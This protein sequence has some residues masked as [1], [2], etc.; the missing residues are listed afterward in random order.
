MHVDSRAGASSSSED[1]TRP[2][3]P[4]P[5]LAAQFAPPAVRS[6]IVPRTALLRRLLADRQA[7]VVAVV[8]PPG[9][10]KTTLLAQWAARDRRPFAWLSLDARCNDPVVLVASLAV[11]LSQGVPVPPAV[12]DHLVAAHRP[13][14]EAVVAELAAAVARARR[15][16]VLVLDD[17]HLLTD[18]EGLDALRTLLHHLPVDCGFAVAGRREPPLGLPRLRGEGRV[19]DI[20]AAELRLDA[21]GARDL[22]AAAGVELPS[23]RVVDLVAATEG[24]PIGLYFAALAH[25]G[26]AGPP[27]PVEGFSGEDRLLADYL[28]TEVL[29]HLPAHRRRFLT[30]TSVL[31]ELSGPLCDA[32]LE[33]SGSAADLEEIEASNLLLV[34]LDRQRHWYRFHRLFQGLLRHE[35]EREEPEAVRPLAG[36]ASRWCETHDLFDSAVRYAQVAGDVGRVNEILRRGTMRQFAA[37]RAA[38]LQEWFGWLAEQGGVDGGVA[39]LGAWVSALSGRPAEADHWAA[40]ARAGDPTAEQPDGSP[41][42]AWVH[43]V[44]AVMAHSAP[45][46]RRDAEQ[47]LRLLSPASQWRGVAAAGLGIAQLLDGDPDRADRTLADAV[48]V[49]LHVGA[50]TASAVALAVRALIAM[51]RDA[52]P[53]AD[54]FLDEAAEVIANGHLQGYPT[55]GIDHAA[56]ACVAAHR[57]DLPAARVQLTAAARVLPTLTRALGPLAVLTRVHL[58]RAALAISDVPTATSLLGEAEQLLAGGLRFDPV[59]KDLQRLGTAI[60]QLGS[61]PPAPPLTPAELRLLP[62][63][64]TQR[65][66]RE[67][68][69]QQIL[70]VHTVKAQVTSIYRKLGVSSRTQAIDRARSVGLLADPPPVE[71]VAR[72]RPVSPIPPPRAGMPRDQHTGSRSAPSGSGPAAQS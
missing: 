11:A 26:G 24:W 14:R 9:Y 64:S 12:F 61:T 38:A 69:E 72:P 36:R 2:P 30:R 19:L 44:C 27:A 33:R 40:F 60:E 31:D 50:L 49:G 35:L 48:E 68:A 58:A 66:L 22:L 13:Q 5:L 55:V 23:A 17:A 51:S 56:R 43:T 39:A 47:A 42:G 54:G 34:P 65:S 62:L 46:M 71:P 70:S 25:R 52:W 57:H 16:F 4:V 67:I 32:T 1:E 53:A 20:G 7:Q 15:P 59:Q 41:L 8:G 6:G 3:L 28:R 10:G 37:G 21:G 45:Q 18:T 63:L 29:D